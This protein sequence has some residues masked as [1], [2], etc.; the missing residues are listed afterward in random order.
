[1]LQDVYNKNLHAQIYIRM[2][3]INITKPHSLLTIFCSKPCIRQK[4][5]RLNTS[6]YT[7]TFMWVFLPGTRFIIV[8]LNEIFKSRS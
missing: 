6:S 4:T 1:M 8:L 3:L 7:H 5:K 2:L